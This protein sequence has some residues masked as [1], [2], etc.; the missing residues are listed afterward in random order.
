MTGA[1]ILSLENLMACMPDAGNRADL[2]YQALDS[3]MSEFGIESAL[4][5]ACFLAQLAHESGSLRYTAEIWG[6]TTAQLGYESRSDLGN[7]QPGDGRRFKGRG[8]I[9]IT[10]R[11][12]TL[13]CLRALDHKDDDLGYLETPLGAARSAGWFW[14]DRGLNEIAALGNF[15]TLTKKINGGYIGLDERIKHYLRI[16][17]V[18]GA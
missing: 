12:N 14:K 11:A 1:V 7:T 4:Q 2:Y 17:K 18:L 13:R 9:Q 8:L 15:G 5:Q 3:A 16:T 10:G 6:P